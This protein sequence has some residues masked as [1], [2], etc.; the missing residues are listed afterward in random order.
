MNL[1]LSTVLIA[2]ILSG[3][4]P[5]GSPFSKFC[6]KRDNDGRQ[7]CCYV[8]D[9][10]AIKCI[11]ETISNNAEMRRIQADLLRRAAEAR[12]AAEHPASPKE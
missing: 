10:T 4:S 6:G 9:G 2:A 8:A 1:A 5:A 11:E 3:E 12:R 7:V